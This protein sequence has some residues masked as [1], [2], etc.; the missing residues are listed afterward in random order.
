[1]VLFMLLGLRLWF[2][3]ERVHV[4]FFF[5]GGG[6]VYGFFGGAFM[7]LGEAFMVFFWGGVVMVLGGGGLWFCG[8]IYTCG[9]GVSGFCG[10]SVYGFLGGGGVYGFGRGRLWLLGW[11]P[12]WFSRGWSMVLVCW[13][14]V[15]FASL[16]LCGGE[17]EVGGVSLPEGV[18]GAV[19]LRGAGCDVSACWREAW[20]D[21]WKPKEPEPCEVK[22]SRGI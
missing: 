16:P 19:L 5:L 22:A 14:E 18:F 12:L 2:W 17:V 10:Q 11:R 1:M 20:A 9:E 7:V 8:G 21:Q 3:G 15:G 4:F 6:G 13:R